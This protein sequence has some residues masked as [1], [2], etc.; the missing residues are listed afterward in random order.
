M[1]EEED[2]LRA[3]ELQNDYYTGNRPPTAVARGTNNTRS[4]AVIEDDFGGM[5]YRAPDETRFD[6][7][8]PDPREELFG[9]EWDMNEH[10]GVPALSGGGNANRGRGGARAGN[11]DDEV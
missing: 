1:Q 6:R 5:G 9:D 2:L 8:I 11:D 10:I 3:Q 7:L 4:N